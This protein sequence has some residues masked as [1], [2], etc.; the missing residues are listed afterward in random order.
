[1]DVL[2]H[3][4]PERGVDHLVLFDPRFSGE[5]LGD[6]GRLEVILGAGE[7]GHL[8]VRAREALEERV[9]ERFDADHEGKTRNEASG[10]VNA[11]RSR[12]G[13]RG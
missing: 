13:V 12:A 11:E 10:V 9:L 5:L 3:A 1:V 8:D 7:I 2:L 6:H 4:V